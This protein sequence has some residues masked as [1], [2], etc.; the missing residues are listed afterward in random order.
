LFI[1]IW[2][3]S[4]AR[5]QARVQE[6]EAVLAEPVRSARAP[7]AA[8]TASRRQ[9]IK[10]IGASSFRNAES[11]PGLALYCIL[12]DPRKFHLCNPLK[13]KDLSGI[14]DWHGHCNCSFEEL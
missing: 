7:E 10:A 11:P 12:H 5:P 2:Q 13:L 8:F 1:Y 6:A 3:Q 9:A 14:R 4:Q